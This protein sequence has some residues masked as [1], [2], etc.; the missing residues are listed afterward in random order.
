MYFTETHIYIPTAYFTLQKHTYKCQLLSCTQQ[1]YTF[2]CPQL[3]W[4]LHKH[5]LPCPLHNTL[6]TNTPSH[7]HCILYSTHTHMPSAILTFIETH[8]Y[9]STGILHSKET[10]IHIPP[11]YCTFSEIHIH[12]PIAINAPNRNTYSQPHYHQC[13]IQKYTFT[14]TLY[15]TL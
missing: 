1:K 15:T 5:T 3:S 2:T 4:T 12:M 9:M 7:N 10:H 8:I 11:S 13:I 6:Y 14:G